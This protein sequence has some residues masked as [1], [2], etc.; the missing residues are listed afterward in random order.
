MTKKTAIIY[1]Y[2]FIA[3]LAF[4]L[5][6][7]LNANADPRDCCLE[8]CAPPYEAYPSHEGTRAKNGD[9]PFVASPACPDPWAWLC[10]D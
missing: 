5:G 4:A 8:W 10:P 7:N 9:C 3:T 1:A 2:L 6:F